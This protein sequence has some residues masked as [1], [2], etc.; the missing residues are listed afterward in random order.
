MCA[1]ITGLERN[2]LGALLLV[3]AYLAEAAR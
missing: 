1:V 3:A 2:E